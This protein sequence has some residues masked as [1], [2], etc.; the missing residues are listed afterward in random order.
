MCGP[1]TCGNLASVRS[2]RRGYAHANRY[3][4]RR[5]STK[6]MFTH[7]FTSF[8]VRL[9]YDTHWKLGNIIRNYPST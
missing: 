2:R 5:G 4:H 9:E 1:R 7:R 8:K 6:A 3:A